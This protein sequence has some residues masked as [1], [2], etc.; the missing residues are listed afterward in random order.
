MSRCTSYHDEHE[1]GRC[2]K[3]D[4]HPGQAHLAVAGGVSVEWRDPG[5]LGLDCCPRPSG[6]A[7]DCRRG[8]FTVERLCSRCM[9]RA[10]RIA[11]GLGE[12]FDFEHIPPCPGCSELRC[13]C[14]PTRRELAEGWD[15]DTAWGA[16]D[17]D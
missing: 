1:S 4:G 8:P 15:S 11:D 2:V 17:G 10:W 9:V 14:P 12:P 5:L 6:S 3:A 7:Y 13:E 16:L